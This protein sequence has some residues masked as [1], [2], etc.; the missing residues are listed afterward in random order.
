MSDN[1]PWVT[2]VRPQGACPAAAKLSA[3]IRPALP[4]G[5][6]ATAPEAVT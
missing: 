2:D 4:A 5:K 6:G 1:V 3:Y